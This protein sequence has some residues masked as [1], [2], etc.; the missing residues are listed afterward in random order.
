MQKY[1]QIK[2]KALTNFIKNNQIYVI[3]KGL[4]NSEIL[5]R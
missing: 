5:T 1:R 4:K 3:K 2:N